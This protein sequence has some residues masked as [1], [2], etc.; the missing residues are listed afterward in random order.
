V[1]CKAKSGVFFAD[2]ATFARERLRP[3]KAGD[4]PEIDM[5]AAAAEKHQRKKPTINQTVSGGN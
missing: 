1:I 3:G 4:K 5:A 2:Y